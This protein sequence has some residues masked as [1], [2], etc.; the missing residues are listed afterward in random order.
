MVD[1]R[2]AGP[3]DAV[4][5]ARVVRGAFG[6]EEGP[7]LIALIAELDRHPCGR[8]HLAF[9]A[10]DTADDVLG[11]ALVTRSRLDTARALID[12][13]QLAPLAVR[14]DVQGQGIGASLLDHAVAAAQ[15]AGLPIIFLEGDPGYYAR[16][17]WEP[18]GP[19]GFRKP[20]LRIPDAAFQCIRL[21]GYED[22]MTGTLVYPE[23]FWDADAVGL[24]SPETAAEFASEVAAGREG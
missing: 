22:W 9:V 21:A 23:P 11:Y 17:D 19:L 18:G 10:V 13:A 15:D 8:D 12:V 6:E 2:R 24:R 20:S 5:I 4:G 3:A 14:P 7:G 1:I 16:L